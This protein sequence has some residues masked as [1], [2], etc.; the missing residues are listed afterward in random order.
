[1]RGRTNVHGGGSIVNSII[2]EYTVASGGNVKAGEFVR[3]VNDNNL[4][5]TNSMFGNNQCEKLDM[6]LLNDK[7]VFIVYKENFNL[8]GVICEINNDTI[9]FSP[10]L[11]ISTGVISLKKIS[12][13]K[14][15]DNKIVVVRDENNYIVATLCNI[16]DSITIEN[17]Y[18]ITSC[19][20]LIGLKSFLLC[21]NKFCIVFGKTSLLQA[22]ICEI[23]NNSI[24]IGSIL[25]L[26]TKYYSGESFA[27]S[28]VEDNKFIVVHG[29]ANSSNTNHLYGMIC[30]INGNMITKHNDTILKDATQQLNAGYVTGIVMLEKNKFCIANSLAV[31]ICKIKGNNIIMYPEVRLISDNYYDN[32][33]PIVL[34]KNNLFFQFT[35]K[36]TDY[37]YYGHHLWCKVYNNIVNVEMEKELENSVSTSSNYIVSSTLVINNNLLFLIRC[38]QYSNFNY[39][40]IKHHYNEIS[41]A[42]GFEKNILGL[43]KTSGSS[44]KT[45]KVYVPKESEEI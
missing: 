36:T 8:N 26:D 15:K 4:D 35:K 43:A 5:I 33:Q 34:G 30:T 41:K 7:K 20:N 27:A 12:L 22:V 44:G 13:V 19:T 37:A 6:I 21:N 9:S 16:S 42:L 28:K 11:A 45:I 29:G 24:E 1:M 23:S 38:S 25:T 10:S 18:N 32:S 3:Y 2:E 14:L 17:T 39:Y 40:L 31:S